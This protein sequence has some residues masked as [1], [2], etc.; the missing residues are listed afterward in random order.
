MTW[1][2]RLVRLSRALTGATQGEFAEQAGV[3]RAMLAH[4]ELGRCEP[5][6]EHLK[7][8]AQA[9]GLTIPEGQ[10]ILTYADALRRPRQRAGQG[11]E[12]LNADLTALVSR[13][14]QSLLRGPLPGD[15]SSTEHVEEQWSILEN[16]SEEQRL[17]VVRTARS[18]QS[19]ALAERV[20]A[21]AAMGASEPGRAASLERL[22]REIEGSFPNPVAPGAA[23][24]SG[25]PPS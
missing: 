3:D 24:G 19:P 15:A 1:K 4:Y 5:G 8:L 10:Q 11:I 12:A 7:N 9:A 18:F 14:Y 13:V 22:A 6:P 2:N 16:L 23:F 20:R 25:R 21:E 17:A